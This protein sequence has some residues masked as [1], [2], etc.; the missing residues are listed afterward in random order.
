[1]N[2]AIRNNS[3]EVAAV[4]TFQNFKP[5]NNAK[6][7]QFCTFVAKLWELSDYSKYTA[8]Y[9]RRY[10]DYLLFIYAL[11]KAICFIKYHCSKCRGSLTSAIRQCRSNKAGVSPHIDHWVLAHTTR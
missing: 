6:I 5:D 7:W 3:P 11:N 9:S 1:M 8:G 10:A 2:V 4:L